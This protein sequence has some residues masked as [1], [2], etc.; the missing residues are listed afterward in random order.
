MVDG[1]HISMR[2]FEAEVEEYGRIKFNHIDIEIKF[3]KETDFQINRAYEENMPKTVSNGLTTNHS[4]VP[5][6]TVTIDEKEIIATVSQYNDFTNRT[7][8]ELLN[9]WELIL[10]K[11][12]TVL[13]LNKLPSIYTDQIG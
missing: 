6:P 7:L 12:C 13:M 9:Q 3:D 11:S 8:G 4:S 5:G 10:A 2:T 1:T